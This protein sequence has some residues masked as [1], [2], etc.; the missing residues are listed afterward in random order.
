MKA[1]TDSR[2][3][4]AVFALQLVLLSAFA[5]LLA[6]C[7]HSRAAHPDDAG[8]RQFLA[9]YFSTWS[10]RDM[11]G[12]GACFHPSARV[13]FVAKSGEVSSD[14]LTNFLHG[15]KLAHETASDPMT[16][17]PLVMT[18]QG[19]AKV[20]QASVTWVL[21]KGASEERGTDFFTLKREGNGWKIVS[22]VFYGE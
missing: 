17:K 15:Q 8:I 21:T 22:L 10:A 13:F 4:G 19:D 9:R 14:G 11:E 20:V 16:E 2:G 12:Y 7:A 1:V 6:G 5:W 3:R 18:I